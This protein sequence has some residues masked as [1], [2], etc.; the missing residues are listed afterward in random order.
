MLPGFVDVQV[1]SLVGTL[2]WHVHL[3]SFLVPQH[4]NAGMFVCLVLFVVVSLA[5]PLVQPVVYCSR[6]G[7]LDVTLTVEAIT[8]KTSHFEFNTRAYDGSVPGKPPSLTAYL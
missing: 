3:R 5:K 1:P 8:W 2:V 7:M 4:V 6:D